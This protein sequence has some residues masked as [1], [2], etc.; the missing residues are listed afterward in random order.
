MY[1]NSPLKLPGPM[2]SGMFL[3]SPCLHPILHPEPNFPSMH[4]CF[5]LKYLCL[6]K[7]FVIF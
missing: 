7:K 5:V 4:S 2:E 3:L 6:D 1:T